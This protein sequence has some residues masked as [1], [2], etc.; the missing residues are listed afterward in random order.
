MFNSGTISGSGTGTSG[1]GVQLAAGG[2]LTNTSGGG[3]TGVTFGVKTKAA[4]T[5]VND[6][7][8]D[9]TGTDGFGLY[10]RGGSVTNQT[11]GTIEGGYC[12]VDALGGTVTNYGLIDG[13]GAVPDGI[14]VHDSAVVVNSAG[15]TILSPTFIGVETYDGP[16]TVTNAGLISASYGI[17]F[18]GGGAVTNAA[19]GTIAGD[20]FG[21]KSVKL[22]TVVNAGMISATGSA[23]DS[24]LLT[25]G[26]AN[27]VV[28]D[29]GATFTSKV[30]GGNTI[31]A[32][33]VSTLELAAGTS[34][35]SLTALGGRY[36][37]FGQIIVDPG[38]SW[39]FSGGAQ[40]GA[41]VTLTMDGA[42]VDTSAGLDDS[43]IRPG[44]LR[45]VDH[46]RSER[47]RR[48]HHRRQRHTAE[49]G[50]HTARHDDRLR[51]C[52][53]LAVPEC[54]QNRRRRD[55]RLR[56][57]RH[58]RA[59]RHQRCDR[60][61]CGQRRHAAGQPGLQLA[62]LPADVRRL[63][64]RDLSARHQQQKHADHPGRRALLRRRHTHPYGPW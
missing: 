14:E 11:G 33:A 17:L 47:H 40:V 39:R 51:R 50:R 22:A 12:G 48:H 36:I 44:R 19:G 9:A 55:I 42:T 28:V 61:Q 24:V 10:F 34:T 52:L 25:A 20:I 54:P 41:G 6:G 63:H 26:Y 58:D 37:D 2:A 57:R 38:A 15:G 43:G 13:T 3:I 8:I 23:A 4:T 16:V 35:G 60:H 49:P 21:V 1:Y 64:Q 53:G 62:D 32:T 30:D 18:L 59:R 29:P 56:Q 31:G 7:S 27:R 46:R 5:I 45:H